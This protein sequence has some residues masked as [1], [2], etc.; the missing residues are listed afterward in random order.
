MPLTSGGLREIGELEDEEWMTSGLSKFIVAVKL[1]KVNV[2]ILTI[3][4]VV[5]TSYFPPIAL[6]L[7]NVPW[8]WQIPPIRHMNESWSRMAYSV[9]FQRLLGSNKTYKKEWES[10]KHI[11]DIIWGLYFF[12]WALV[13]PARCIVVNILKIQKISLHFTA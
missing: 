4:L 5:T 2:R 10:K 8:L 1:W 7:Y 13:I 9:S 11:K 12:Q 6:I 3:N